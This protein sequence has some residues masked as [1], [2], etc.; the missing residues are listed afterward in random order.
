MKS[1]VNINDSSF[2]SFILDPNTCLLIDTVSYDTQERNSLTIQV[3]NIQIEL[4]NAL[5]RLDEE[6]EAANTARANA[7]KWQTEL[8][9]LKS[10]F[11]KELLAR[12]EE[13]EDAR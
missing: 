6:T 10:R 8:Q 9:T 1:K 11:E 4:D 7:G 5:A 12:T 3:T 2:I 13:L